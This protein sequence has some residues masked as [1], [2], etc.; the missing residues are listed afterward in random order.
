MRAGLGTALALVLVMSEMRW[1]NLL[2]AS[3]RACAELADLEA[4]LEDLQAGLPS[5][6]ETDR[7]R[8]LQRTMTLTDSAALAALEVRNSVRMLVSE[9]QRTEDEGNDSTSDAAEP[10]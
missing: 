1:N 10:S 4:R 6:R 5:G 9:L 3:E 2:A 7:E 8:F